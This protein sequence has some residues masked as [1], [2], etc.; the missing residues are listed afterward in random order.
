[1]AQWKSAK[2]IRKPTERDFKEG[3]AVHVLRETKRT[4][5][6]SRKGLGSGLRNVSRSYLYGIFWFG[7]LTA[8]IPAILSGMV[9]Q[10]LLFIAMFYGIQ[11]GFRKGFKHATPFLAGGKPPPPEPID[12]AELFD[13]AQHV[14]VSLASSD[15]RSRQSGDFKLAFPV[16]MRQAMALAIPGLVLL[17]VSLGAG[18]FTF[19][20]GI[21]LLG[22]A[23]LILFKAVADRDLL[24]FDHR[25]I[26]VDTLLRKGT[27][28]WDKV[29]DVSARTYPRWNLKMLLTVGSRRVIVIAGRDGRN[30]PTRLLI[31][32]DLLD[33]DK[34]GLTA[35]I[36]DLLCCRAAAGEVVPSW[37]QPSAP[38]PTTVTPASDPRETFDPDA[39]MARYLA[40]RA[41]IVE[42][43]RPDLSAGLTAPPLLERK[44]FG[45]K[46]A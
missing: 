3:T 4:A 7:I 46:V 30:A 28:A 41:R 2:M 17:L 44:S 27:L 40:E 22:T 39:I 19:V 16:A 26:T 23:I 42:D 11:Q 32:I 43:V 36:A 24:T 21:A 31:P 29:A 18:P 13:A 1:M 37:Q 10:G 25:S 20:P 45:R 38:Q 8:A 14:A 15:G 6:E 5:V 12:P 33:L 35:L 34:D 9:W